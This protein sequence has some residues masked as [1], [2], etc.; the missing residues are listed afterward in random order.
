MARNRKSRESPKTWDF[1]AITNMR[2]EDDGRCKKT[3]H[4]GAVLTSDFMMHKRDLPWA[5]LGK[6]PSRIVNELKGVNWGTV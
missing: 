1:A 3:G 2:S 5:V 4:P 6:V